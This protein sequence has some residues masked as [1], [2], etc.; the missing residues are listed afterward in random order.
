LYFSTIFSKK[1]QTVS[2]LFLDRRLVEFRQE[3]V[4]LDFRLP[5]CEP[6]FAFARADGIEFPSGLCG[7]V[8]L[9]NV[10]PIAEVPIRDAAVRPFM[11]S[12]VLYP[13]FEF[14]TSG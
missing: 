7:P 8:R 6:V 4:A 1:D 12:R 13:H 2:D 9:Q 11:D 3:L 10:V 14:Q 5:L